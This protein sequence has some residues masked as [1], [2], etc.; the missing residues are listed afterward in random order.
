MVEDVDL[1]PETWGWKKC[2]LFAILKRINSGLYNGQKAGSS[3][4]CS[5]HIAMTNEIFK[6]Q[7]ERETG[8]DKEKGRNETR[9]T[10]SS[11]GTR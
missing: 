2:H 4:F 1:T 6:R 8:T 3:P 10:Q 7:E 5:E 9:K 11:F